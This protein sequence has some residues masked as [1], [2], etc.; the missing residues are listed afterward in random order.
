MNTI[1]HLQQQY[2]SLLQPSEPLIAD[3]TRLEGD[4]LILGAGG[5]MGPALAKLARTAVVKS[6]TKKRIIAVSRFSETG[7]AEELRGAG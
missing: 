4:I 1:N 6:G 5:K 2:D 3:I 7:L